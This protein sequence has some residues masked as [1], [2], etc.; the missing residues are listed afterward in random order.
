LAPSKHPFAYRDFRYF[1]LARGC[2]TLAQNCMVV[3]IGWQVYDVARRTLEP[4]QAALWLGLIG[5]VQFA[6]VFLL[7]LVSGWVADRLDRRLIV[8]LCVGM[9]LLC[10]AT[11]AAGNWLGRISFAPLFAVAVVLGVARAFYAPA[12][13]AIAPNLVAREALPRAI[14]SNSII[15]RVGAILG[16]AVG[17]TLYAV[18]VHLPY[19]V[20]MGLFSCAL[21]C[22]FMLRPI[23]V[24]NMDRSQHPW[25]QM[26]D[27]LRY[28]RQNRLVLGAISLDLFAV[29]LGGATALLPIYARD[30]L[31]IG[32]SG[33]GCLRAAPPVGAL[34]TAAWFSFRPMQDNVG[35]KM[36]VAVGVYGAATAVFGLSRW[37][38]LSLACLAILGAA[39]MFS[40]YVRQ[41]LIQIS[42][43]NEMRGRVGAFSSMFVSASNELGEAE[44][45][46]LAAAV[47]PTAAVVIGGVG[48]IG[49]AALW[50]R[51][52]PMLRNARRFE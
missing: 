16:P 36:L 42:T 25:Q 45:G 32:P 11:L 13:S 48:A 1:W 41:S 12:Q 10:A 7:T 20:S 26:I 2:T 44:S 38:P 46:F 52:F 22:M 18:A 4:Q 49:V 47:G 35:V 50:S 15:T 24:A 14:A 6:P 8:R 17:G 9:Q 51:W 39:D 43:P 21:V 5:L 28:V 30:V 27:G 23:E 37:V 3:V 34:L 31:Q 19:A 40:L 33:L 29:L